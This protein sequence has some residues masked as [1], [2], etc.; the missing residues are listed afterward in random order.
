MKRRKS[1]ASKVKLH[2]QATDWLLALETK[3]RTE[4]SNDLSLS[5]LELL[6]M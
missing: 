1:K 4:L 6:E 2:H 5:P 3:H